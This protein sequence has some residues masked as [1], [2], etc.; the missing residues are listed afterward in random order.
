MSG[1][2]SIQKK[3]QEYFDELYIRL[4][5]DNLFD[6]IIPDYYVLGEF[7]PKGKFKETAIRSVETLEVDGKKTIKLFIGPIGRRVVSGMYK[8]KS[9]CFLC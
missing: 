8:P 6:E 9:H 4:G 1:K 5:I 2:S 7:Q 3:V